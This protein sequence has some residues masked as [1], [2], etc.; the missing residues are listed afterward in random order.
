MHA[1]CAVADKTVARLFFFAFYVMV[2][3]VVL[4]LFI[5][6]VLEA[7][8]MQL[9]IQGEEDDAAGGAGAGDSGGSAGLQALNKSAEAQARSGGKRHVW[10]VRMVPRDA[11]SLLRDM[12]ARQLMRDLLTGERHGNDDESLLDMLRVREEQTKTTSS[13][14]LLSSIFAVNL[15]NTGGDS[16]PASRM[17]HSFTS[18]PASRMA[19]ADHSFTS[20]GQHDY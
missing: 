17:D 12:F 16:R 8:I 6:F 9:E 7:F 11:T 13:N 3:I 14:L 19:Q 18:R 2:P 1:G 20:T 4:N 5:A 15:T 10:K